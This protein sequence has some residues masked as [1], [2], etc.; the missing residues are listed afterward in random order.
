MLFRAVAVRQQYECI[1][2]FSL[3]LMVLNIFCS[4]VDGSGKRGVIAKIYRKDRQV[5]RE[6]LSQINAVFI[7]IRQISCGSMANNAVSL[8]LLA[9]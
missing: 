9:V 5:Y 2:I 8:S 3:F 7:T 1:S 4:A 6:K